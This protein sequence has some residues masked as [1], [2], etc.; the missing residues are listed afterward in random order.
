MAGHSKWKNIQKRKNAQDSKRG[1]IFMKLAKE[2][3]VAAK[4]GG[5]DPE[6][7]ANLRLVIDK[8]KGANM[9]NDNIDRAIKKAAG[10]H[11]GNNYEDIT[12][13]GYGPS[14]IAVMVT[15]LTD[16]KNRTATNVRTA[17]N[18]NGG[19]LGE[20]GCVSYMF[21]RK[22]FI[23][24][25]RTDLKTAEDEMML[26]AIEAGAEDLQ[27]SHN[28]FEIFTEPEKFEEV[29]KALEGKYP[30]V[31]AEVTMIPQTFAEVDQ[32][33]AEKLEKLID[34]LEDDDD[35]QEVYTNFSS[36]AEED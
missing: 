2:L 24:I 25:D 10:N 12:Y 15:C 16:N 5:T 14:G 35:V 9:P 7:N 21:D 30:I 18:K 13:E 36:S 27:T 20:S 19:S 6:S 23:A 28:L 29:R 17:F 8:A 26:E 1:K 33:A 31:S 22:G 4:Q 3:Y 11:D 34:M 32:A